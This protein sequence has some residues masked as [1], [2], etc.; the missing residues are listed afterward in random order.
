M[1]TS[2]SKGP[3]DYCGVRVE[4]LH[5]FDSPVKARTCNEHFANAL[6]GELPDLQYAGEKIAAVVPRR[7]APSGKPRRVIRDSVRG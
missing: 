5:Q 3:C 7:R 1:S 6:R 2:P 4:A